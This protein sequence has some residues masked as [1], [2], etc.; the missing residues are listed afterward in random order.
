MGE[1][2]T[3]CKKFSSPPSPLSFQKLPNEGFLEFLKMI[4]FSALDEIYKKQA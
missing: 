1:R 2:K 3:F 4:F